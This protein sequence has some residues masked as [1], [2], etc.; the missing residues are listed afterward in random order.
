M[1]ASSAASRSSLAER[2]R[3]A[4]LRVTGPRLR[5]LQAMLAAGGHRSVDEIR[6][7]LER[8]RMPLSRGSV[9]QVTE[10][11]VAA[12]LVMIADAG[13]GRTLYEV[14]TSWHHH[15]VCRRCGRVIDVACAVGE[16][17]CLEPDWLPGRA[18]E[19]QVIWRGLCDSCT[20]S[21]ELDR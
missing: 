10:A 17:P 7:E 8:N 6:A 20:T 14:M 13:P 1:D 3:S 2:L 4:G 21:S 19:A 16:K 11:L 12:G 9:Y 15:F 5:V 18:D